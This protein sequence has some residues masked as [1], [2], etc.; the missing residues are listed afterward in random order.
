[1]IALVNSY[2]FSY[3]I[4]AALPITV[5]KLIC[6]LIEYTCRQ[7][8]TSSSLQGAFTA[9]DIFSNFFDFSMLYPPKKKIKYKIMTG[10]SSFFAHTLKLSPL[11]SWK[12]FALG[13]HR[14]PL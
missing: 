10:A 2:R 8:T 4:I 3:L 12:T 6:L 13:C 14:F 9:V 11:L 5:V 1:M 7:A